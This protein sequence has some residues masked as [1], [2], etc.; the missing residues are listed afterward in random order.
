MKYT[1]IKA[2]CI[3]QDMAAK[4]FAAAYDRMTEQDKQSAFADLLTDLQSGQATWYH[5][6][7]D[8]VDLHMVTRVANDALMID[9]I[10][11]KGLMRAAPD[12]IRR[13]HAV[14]YR[15][16]GFETLKQGMRKMLLTFGFEVV[17][18][19]EDGATYHEKTLRGCYDF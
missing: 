3:T 17:E 18:R 14:G 7:S 9:A 15:A 5:L 11:G 2:S 12:I 19:F 8:N 10:Q 4:H 6:R 1:I 13:A 16:L